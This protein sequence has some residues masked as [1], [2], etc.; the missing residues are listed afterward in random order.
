MTIQVFGTTFTFDPN[1]VIFELE[2]RNEQPCYEIDS[3]QPYSCFACKERYKKPVTCEFCAMKFC[4][5]CCVRFRT[6]PNSIKLENGS[7][8]L[9]K[10]CKICDRKFLMLK[11]YKKKIKPMENRDD[12]MRHIVQAYEMKLNK[13]QFE[14]VNEQRI[15][16]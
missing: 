10:I 14:I 3:L 9:G 6:F 5:D 8:I 4:N 2:M 16:Q 12:E 1:E 15:Q 13:A 11:Q 7:K